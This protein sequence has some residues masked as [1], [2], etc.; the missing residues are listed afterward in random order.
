MGS[1]PAAASTELPVPN[2]DIRPCANVQAIL[3]HI[4]ADTARWSPTKHPFDDTIATRLAT[5][6]A[7]MNQQ[8]MT[9]DY[10]LRKAV[11][12]TST[13]F[14]LVSRSIAAHSQKQLNHAVK[15]SQVAYA[16]L[17]KICH[18]SSN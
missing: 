2:A 12:D 7:Y 1:L 11:S 5:E 10:R 16:V 17:K 3:S 14:G 18:Y 15:Q 6:T 8:A 4:A 13:A 9:A